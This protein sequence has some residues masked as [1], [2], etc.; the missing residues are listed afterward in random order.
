[1]IVLYAAPQSVNTPQGLFPRGYFL[2]KMSQLTDTRISIL[3]MLVLRIY[4][5]ITMETSIITIG[6]SKGIR[7]PKPLLEESGLSGKVRLKATK[8]RIS[9]VIIKPEKK[10]SETALLS[11]K[12]LSRDWLRPEEEKAWA[13]LQ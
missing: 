4:N 13:N 6:N 1:M 8:G 12:I 3:T 11:E 10:I 9:I 2:Y 7:I 5:V